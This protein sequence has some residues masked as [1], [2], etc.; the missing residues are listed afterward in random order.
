MRG[1]VRTV[2]RELARIARAQHGV[3]TRTELLRAGL[4]ATEIDRRVSKG[5]LIP[6]HRGVYRVGHC[7]PSLEARYLAAV[8]ACGERALLSG[9]AAGHLY[10][11]LRRAPQRPEV[12]APTER[13][14]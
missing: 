6:Q 12:T 10:G 8:L 7:A 14:V 4:S 3:A 9:R 2:E 11:L 1:Q 13:R 5:A